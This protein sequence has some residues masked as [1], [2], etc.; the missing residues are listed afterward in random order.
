MKILLEHIKNCILT[1]AWL[2]NLILH[3]LPAELQI[4]KFKRAPSVVT[5]EI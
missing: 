4:S 5:G 1:V 3:R 2:M